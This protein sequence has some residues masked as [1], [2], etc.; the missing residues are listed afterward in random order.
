MGNKI[1]MIG[2]QFGDWIVIS[3]SDMINKSN[4][5]YYHCKC[6][7]GYIGEIQGGALRSGASKGCLRCGYK[8]ISKKLKDRPSPTKLERGISQRNVLYNRYKISAKRRG[9]EFD[10]PI[11]LFEI[12]TKQ[13]CHYCGTQPSQIARGK[14]TNGEYIYNGIDRIDNDIGYKE[15]NL[16][17]CCKFCNRAKD[18]LT[19]DEFLIKIKQIYYKIRE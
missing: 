12:I 2:K 5:I 10:I 15:D 7:C 1:N 14:Q 11:E 6:K 9:I 8:K 18:I 13:K 4:N 3:Q 16:V 19:K 17:P